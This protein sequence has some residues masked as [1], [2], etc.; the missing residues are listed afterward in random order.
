MIKKA[1][2]QILPIA[3]CVLG[4]PLVGQSS[5]GSNARA[6][7]SDDFSS[8]PT[9]SRPQIRYWIPGAAV[10]NQGIRE[11]FED[12]R[13]AG[14]GGVEID[15]FPL[16]KGIPPEYGWGTDAW[17][18]LVRFIADEAMKD[19]MTVDFT[20]GPSWPIAM[21]SI[22]SADDPAALYELTYGSQSVAGGE[23]FSGV[24]PQR[25]KKR[26]EGTTKLIAVLAYRTPGKKVLDFSS[27]VDLTSRTVI[28]TQDNS[29]ST[30]Q[31]Q[32]PEG[33]DP[34]TILTF[35][36]QPAAQKID[37]LYVIDHFGRAGTAAVEDYWEH[38]ALTSLGNR[39]EPVRSIFNDSLEYAVSMEWTR[40]MRDSFR[41][42][43][44]YD[45]V[46][47]LPFL[48]DSSVYPP[49]DLPRYTATDQ[50]LMNQVENDYRDQLTSLYISN[51]LRPMEN[52]AQR[53]GL[54]IRAQ[55]AYNK[56]MQIEDAALAVAIPETEALGRSSVDMQRYMSGAV[57]LA[58]KPFYSI[59]TNAEFY[60]DYGQ[61]LRDIL[62]WN[63]RAW[64]AGVNIQ[65]LHGESYSGLFSGV[66]S[67]DG[68][69][70]DLKWPGYSAFETKVSNEWMRQTSP[71]LLRQ[72]V[73]Y[74][75]RVNYILQKQAKVDVAVLDVEPDIYDDS[76]HPHGDG[77][78]V[79][80]D[81]GVLSA[82]GFSY[83]FVTPALLTLPQAVVSQGALDKSGPA[84]KALIIHQ[85]KALTMSTVK[86]LQGLSSNGLKIVFVGETPSGNA[87]YA[88][89]LRG[90]SDALI[91]AAV[92]ALL[93]A[94]NVRYV[95]DY[96][97]VP[98]VLNGL[99]I[100]ADAQPGQPTDV[101]T[102]H[103]ADQSGDYYYLYNY[104]KV[105]DADAKSIGKPK[106][107]T[108]YPD[109]A[110]LAKVPKT[111]VYSLRGHGKPYLL[112]AWTGEIRALPV[113]STSGDRVTVKLDLAADDAVLLALLTDRQAAAN[114][115]RPKKVWLTASDA[116]A[117]ALAYGS[118]GRIYMKGQNHKSYT[119]EWNDGSKGNLTIPEPSGP[120]AIRDWTL[121]VKAIQPPATGSIVFR[122]SKWNTVGTYKLG[123]Q[124]KPWNEIDSSLSRIS[125]TG[126]Y[127]GSFRLDKGWERGGGAYLD[128]GDVSD[129]FSVSINGTLLPPFDQSRSMIDIGSFVKSG[130][131]NISIQIATTLFNA[132]IE[133]KKQYGL[134]GTDG[135]IR[136]IPYTAITFPTAGGQSKAH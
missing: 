16:P 20:N 33:K 81:G 94:P 9:S 96:A 66:G 134:V 42:A 108:Q 82:C 98:A 41:A 29:K 38:Q 27:M 58:G 36:E 56:P 112:D 131:N 10:T 12:I 48:G 17:N 55:V 106:D 19:H 86:T 119:F 77:N 49:N 59:E 83:D 92:S 40:T 4:H 30:V 67:V 122:D 43:K 126:L 105:S 52:M 26:K 136:V 61:T 116:P 21:P 44:G 90:N 80:P 14:F 109:L 69:L 130:L 18:R 13:N 50:R 63:K 65:R 121:T 110:P 117:D 60:N 28:D 78:A 1:L 11:D 127:E 3:V 104:N 89:T 64:A 135:L 74:M 125:G 62:W 54:T 47:Y 79:Y 7:L 85:T 87:S 25:H 84:Y 2:I 6:T 129:A 31:F 99:G 57:H 102:Q 114:G 103:R 5:H 51:D 120:F 37:G 101:L 8:P 133:S 75:S 124:L 111:V 24:V 70:P 73:S 23:L 72:T 113:F 100:V 97:Q 71:A 93:Q 68:H 88:D 15:S 32:A 91:Q 76:A 34:W 45:I 39:I 22:K 35:W 132:A 53:H 128:L 123:D 95:S 46:P 118:D 115:V 107:R